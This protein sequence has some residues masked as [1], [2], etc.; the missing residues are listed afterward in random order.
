MLEGAHVCVC[1]QWS[2]QVCISTEKGRECRQCCSL[3]VC[4]LQV[5]GDDI[6][7]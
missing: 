6:V 3:M 2:R 4:S 5:S 7:A 1:V